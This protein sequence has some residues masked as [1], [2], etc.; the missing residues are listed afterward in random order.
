MSGVASARLKAGATTMT[1]VALMRPRTRRSRIA[2]LTP[3][4]MP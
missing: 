3:G 1:E 4:E 2:A